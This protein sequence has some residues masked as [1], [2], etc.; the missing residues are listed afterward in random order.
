M[1]PLS[2][3]SGSGAYTVDKCLPWATPRSASRGPHRPGAMKLFHQT[4]AKN[5]KAILAKGFTDATGSFGTRERYTGVLLKN[6]PVAVNEID[7][8]LIE[9]ELDEDALATYE[10]REKG[11]SNREWLDHPALVHPHT[12]PPILPRGKSDTEESRDDNLAGPCSTLTAKE[13]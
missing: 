6:Q 11:R 4:T 1:W 8:T 12:N 7:I 10:R 5:A 13:P 2:G 9:V 3:V